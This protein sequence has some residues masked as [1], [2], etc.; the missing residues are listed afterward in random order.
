MNTVQTGDASELSDTT[1]QIKAERTQEHNAKMQAIEAQKERDR[2]AKESKSNSKSSRNGGNMQIASNQNGARANS[3][4]DNENW[5]P[6]FKSKT[7]LTDCTNRAREMRG[8]CLHEDIS[9]PA[10]SRQGQV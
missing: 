5:Q 2:A 1:N 9:K 10:Q 7:T 8:N 4:P 6:A 3:S